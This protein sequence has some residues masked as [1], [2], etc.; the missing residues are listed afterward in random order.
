MA[1]WRGRRNPWECRCSSI[2][3]RL[4]PESEEI[5]KAIGSILT[6]AIDH[7]ETGVHDSD[8]DNNSSVGRPDSDCTKS[9]VSSSEA[10]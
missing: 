6:Q 7:D 8:R 2:V 1:H 3:A 9:S 4:E 10:R 5:F